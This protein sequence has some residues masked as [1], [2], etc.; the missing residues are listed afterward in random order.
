MENSKAVRVGKLKSL[1]ESLKRLI[2]SA[3]ATNQSNI[4]LN[5][6]TYDSFQFIKNFLQFE[7][8]LTLE[9][10]P[11]TCWSLLLDYRFH[12]ILSSVF[13]YL[14]ALSKRLDF[15]SYA[16]DET[17]M[18]QEL[19]INTRALSLFNF[20]T[21]IVFTITELALYCEDHIGKEEVKRQ[22]DALLDKLLEKRFIQSLVDFFQSNQHLMRKVVEARESYEQAAFI[23]ATKII[24]NVTRFKLLKEPTNKW[25]RDVNVI[26]D[27]F[28]RISSE[29]IDQ[30][31]TVNKIFKQ[32]LVSILVNLGFEKKLDQKNK[33]DVQKLI[34]N[35]T[36]L[37][38]EIYYLFVM[39][40]QPNFR[41]LG[42]IINKDYIEML[43]KILAIYINSS[44][45]KLEF[46]ECDFSGIKLVMNESSLFEIAMPFEQRYLMFYFIL[47][48]VNSY[49]AHVYHA[50]SKSQDSVLRPY[51]HLFWRLYLKFLSDKT[52]MVNM[53]LKQ[54]DFIAQFLWFLNSIEF[55]SVSNK[56][57]WLEL[58][59]Y[60]TLFSLANLLQSLYKQETN[61]TI[62]TCYWIMAHIGSESQLRE[63]SFIAEF[64]IDCTFTYLEQYFE[65]TTNSS[66]T[67]I[68]NETLGLDVRPEDYIDCLNRVCLNVDNKRKVHADRRFNVILSVLF[69]ST[70]EENVKL[71]ILNLLIQL[72]FDNEALVEDLAANSEFERFINKF[73][74]VLDK[75]ANRELLT[76][77]E[78]VISIF[79]ESPRS[80]STPRRSNTCMLSFSWLMD[81]VISSSIQKELTTHGFRVNTSP[82]PNSDL[83]FSHTLRCIE[84]SSFFLVGLSESYRLDP[85]LQLEARYAKQLGKS[86]FILNLDDCFNF[87]SENYYIKG[88]WLEEIVRINNRVDFVNNSF[89]LAIK[90]LLEF[91][92]GMATTRRPAALDYIKEESEIKIYKQKTYVDQVFVQRELLPARR[93]KK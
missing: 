51:L 69:S 21:Q 32:E 57:M 31:L 63:H 37:F 77:C 9:E 30:F 70:T 29:S 35:D 90:I 61:Q 47:R 84:E 5:H 25:K 26:L 18:G 42:L 36:E 45:E 40:Q 54:N 8:D 91:L 80:T 44:P 15:N 66:I 7:L 71:S 83:S 39:T 2:R 56:K 3:Q 73:K 87:R 43:Y 93:Y 78:T 16:H 10:P 24:N 92:G 82:R 76:A 20:S 64:L 74:L 85:Y 62:S 53:H 17:K 12:H 34:E 58:N 27:F 88:S 68:E 52:M 86:I 33:H 67:H 75:S 19:D 79:Y 81:S 28:G 13:A 4:V 50:R 14:S 48:I 46:D 38:K 55:F 41:K 89:S 11:T 60:E 72:S 65:V 1:E 22:V 59:V 6:N 49:V 23:S